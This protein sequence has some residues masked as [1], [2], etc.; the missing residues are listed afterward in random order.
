MSYPVAPPDLPTS[1]QV[2]QQSRPALT[3][4]ALATASAPSAEWR[5]QPLPPQLTTTPLPPDTFPLQVPES[6][7]RSLPIH[8]F[9]QA[10]PPVSP[11]VSAPAPAPTVTSPTQGSGI[12]IP[13]PQTPLPPDK[14][15]EPSGDRAP[16]PVSPPSLSP[17]P[18][19]MPNAAPSRI[20]PAPAP[21]S[22]PATPLSPQQQLAN[23]GIL[24]LKADRQD[25]DEKRQIFTAEGNVSM[26]FRQS[27]LTADRLQVNLNNRF[28]V[29][30]GNVTLANGSQVLKGDRF[31][32]NFV[33]GEGSVRGA[34]GDIFVESDDRQVLP[35]LA[36]DISAGTLVGQPD[37]ILQSLDPQAVIGRRAIGITVGS[38]SNPSGAEVVPPRGGG[39]VRRLR[40]EANEAEFYPEG[41]IAKD[42]RIT[43]DP[44]SPPELEMRATTARL[45]RLSPFRDE[46][47]AEKPRLV[48]DQRLSL[49][50]LRNRAII[51]RR[52]RQ[53]ALFTIG[54]DADD[55]GGL[56]IQRSDDLI[57]T[58]AVR[59]SIK[60][61]FYIQRAITGER[62]TNPGDWFGLTAKLSAP[63]GVNGFL[64]SSAE[65]TSLD[66]S[67]IDSRFRANLRAFQPLGSHALSLEA[68]YRDRLFNN[69]LGFQDVQ[70]SVGAL[71]YSPIVKLGDTGINLTYQAGYQLIN[72]ETDRADLLPVVRQNNRINLSRWQASAAL[73]RPFTLWQG[74]PLPATA[75]Q[76]LRFTPNPVVPFVGLSLGA[77]GVTTGYS[78]GDYQNNLTFTAALSARLGHFSKDFLDSTELNIAYS[79]ALPDGLSPFLFDRAV[80]NRV[81]YAG[82]TQQVYGPIRVGV[83]TAWNLETG[84]EISTDYFV[85][86]SRRT[87][88][89]RL[90][91]NP[92]LSLGSISLSINDF[93]WTGGSQPFDNTGVTPVGTGVIRSVEP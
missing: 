83:Q 31:E 55:R 5:P 43:N 76:G 16:K 27:A 17:V 69:S 30:E 2:F 21:G 12:E 7:E 46:I 13:T 51:D 79:Q 58:S 88:S 54:F 47:R 86:Y 82:L 9:S 37:R 34:K 67:K 84:N 28:A 52:P 71:F 62:A 68:S 93:N 8:L 6:Q 38:R 87:H 10:T 73:S 89:V 57:N 23:E 56:F 75:E 49:P 85:E 15:E 80:D 61:Q 14:L 60:P 81:L 19:T 20:N 50:I 78:S 40:F 11:P 70:S 45:T 1:L 22:T 29:A 18:R 72:A 42:V 3:S 44:F 25:Y 48:F 26:K 91:Y 41:W 65:F 4:E 90:R 66:F 59:F 64:T 63:F 33:Q 36:S 24:E 92:V 32:Y 53:P 77:T 39:G 35:P 74:K